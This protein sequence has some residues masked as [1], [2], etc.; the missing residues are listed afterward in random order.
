VARNHRSVTAAAAGGDGGDD[1]GL[2]IV[3]LLYQP[4]S[5]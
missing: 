1:D 3:F 4:K 2:S 5:P